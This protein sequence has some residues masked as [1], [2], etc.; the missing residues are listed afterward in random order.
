MPT[1]HSAPTDVAD[2]GV[3]EAAQQLHSRQLSAAELLSACLRRIETSHG[4]APTFDGAADAVNAWVRVYP[5]LAEKLAREADKRLDREGRS[6]PLVCGIP[7]ALKDLYAVGGL[8]LTASSR[9]LE[10][11]LA[12]EDSEAWVR[13][14]TRGMVLVGHTHTHEFAA[15]GTTDQVGNPW[16]LDRCAGGSSGGSAAALAARMVPA[17]LGTDTL[18]SLRIPSAFCGTSAIKASHGRV[19]MAGIVPL[20]PTLDHAGPL[21]RT[22]ADCSALLDALSADGPEVSPLL[23]PPARLGE[24][25]LEPRATATP[26]AGLVIAVTDRPGRH[27]LDPDVGDGLEAA[28]SACE[29]L[30]ARVVERPAPR[31]LPGEEMSA[32]LLGEMAVLHRQYAARIDRYRPAIR[33]L[34]EA[35]RTANDAATYIRAQ[36]RRAA[37]TAEWENWFADHDIDLVLEPTVPL[38]AH[39]RGKGYERGHAGGE[40]D[41]LIAFSSTWDL[42]GFPA[43]ALPAGVGRRTGLPVG[44]SLVAPRGAESPLVQ[45]AIDLQEHALPPPQPTALDSA[46]VPSREDPSSWQSKQQP[47]RESHYPPG[48]IPI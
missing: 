9:V 30:G 1:S 38:V 18:G 48:P 45:A 14:R 22:V 13:L 24:L 42:T 21:A 8:P 23:P 11:H 4:G 31:E 47:S 33:E 44:I 36:E 20:A 3:L 41:P 2:L 37:F 40:G 19:P 34:V 7:L 32:I 29:R 39:V 15:G 16:S 6:A 28:R 46:S 17:A 12:S 5:D 43:A 27:P 10:G 25:P 35:T 26:L